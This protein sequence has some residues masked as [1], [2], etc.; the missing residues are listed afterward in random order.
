MIVD[1]YKVTPP[2]ILDNSEVTPLSEVFVDACKA[3]PVLC[4]RLVSYEYHYVACMFLDAY[5]TTSVNKSYRCIVQVV[6]RVDS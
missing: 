4:M 2:V 5:K 3:T 6:R 1:G